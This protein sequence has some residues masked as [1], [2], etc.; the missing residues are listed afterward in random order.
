[1][2]PAAVGALWAAWPPGSHGLTSGAPSS[3]PGQGEQCHHGVAGA[4]VG[5]GAVENA[6]MAA[7]QSQPC[8]IFTFVVRVMRV[9]KKGRLCSP[10][11]HLDFFD[12]SLRTPLHG[13]K[14]LKMGFV[15]PCLPSPARLKGREGEWPTPRTAERPIIVVTIT[16][17]N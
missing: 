1:M 7:T 4:F 5:E 10:S 12:S 6:K 14:E 9:K 15:L 16:V 11:C 2:T 3:S 13:E 8:S 17:T